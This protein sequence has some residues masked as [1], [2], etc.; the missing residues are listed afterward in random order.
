MYFCSGALH[1]SILDQLHCDF[2]VSAAIRQHKTSKWF[3][4]F[5]IALALQGPLHFQI[6][7]RLSMSVPAGIF[8]ESALTLE[9]NLGRTDILTI[10]CLSMHDRV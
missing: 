10:L 6:N 2:V 5:K 7:V 1:W 8:T 4:L 3:F 9:V